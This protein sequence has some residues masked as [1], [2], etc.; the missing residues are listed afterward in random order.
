MALPRWTISGSKQVDFRRSRPTT[1]WSPS[2]GR[3]GHQPNRERTSRGTDFAHLHLARSTVV[4]ECESSSG[5]RPPTDA[6]G[7]RVSV[8][9]AGSRNAITSMRSR[10]CGPRLPT[11]YGLRACTWPTFKSREPPA[12]KS[13]ALK[14][15][16]PHRTS[17]GLFSS[18]WEV[19]P[20]SLCT[21]RELEREDVTLERGGG[22]G[23][24]ALTLPAPAPSL[25]GTGERS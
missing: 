16:Y 15:N 8:S 10:S 11:V 24:N 2:S 9:V 20:G 6:F 17:Q 19:P 23:F 13:S 25:S 1:H 18:S 14:G 3:A 21:S 4:L 22:T 12:P 7:S 5:S